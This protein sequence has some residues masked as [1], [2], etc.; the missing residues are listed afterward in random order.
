MNHIEMMRLADA[1]PTKPKRNLNADVDAWVASGGKVTV[2]K[3]ETAI[4]KVGQRDQIQ[5]LTLQR[6][7]R[8][9]KSRLAVLNAV[10]RLGRATSAEIGTLVDVSM[11]RVFAHLARLME[12]GLVKKIR[13][14]AYVY[15]ER[16][17]KNQINPD[18]QS[19]RLARGAA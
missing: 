3:R 18:V 6:K 17:T 1:L 11:P 8:G 13:Q 7:D 19:D 12:L 15:Y 10:D 14:G 5:V 2:V 16:N 4:E 9:E